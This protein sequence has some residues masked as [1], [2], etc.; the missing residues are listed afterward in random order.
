M[1]DNE[2]TLGNKSVII[3]IISLVVVIV[4]GTFAWLSWHT[5]NTAMVLTIGDI[6]GLTISLKPYQINASL[7][8]VSAYTDGIVVDVTAANAKTEADDF[9]LFYQI[10]TIDNELKDAGFKYTITKCSANC[11]N[12][13]NYVLLN[14]AG[15]N[16]V[17]ASSGGTLT[18]YSESIPANTTYKYKV[19]LWID[20]S[21]PNQSAMQGKTFK[22]ELRAEV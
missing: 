16:F 6:Q 5:Q 8:P 10:N 22:G 14:N 17:G 11:T 20:S 1:R 13:S 2:T 9:R 4:T 15:G 18:I 3:A 7:S 19:Y 21:F 12:A